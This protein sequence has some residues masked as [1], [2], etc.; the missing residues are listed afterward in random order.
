[1]LAHQDHAGVGTQ[2][3]QSDP[4]F[5][6]GELTLTEEYEVSRHTIREALRVLRSEG[7]LR[8]QRGRPTVSLARCAI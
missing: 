3:A 1:M 5:D 4:Q 2:L 6:A 8:S 7:V